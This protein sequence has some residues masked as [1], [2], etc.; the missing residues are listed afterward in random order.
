MKRSEFCMFIKIKGIICYPEMTSG[1]L[2]IKIDPRLR[3]LLRSLVVDVIDAMDDIRDTS[4]ED[5][6][7]EATVVAGA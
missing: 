3:L 1:F 5:F 6:G 4:S 7:G 2:S